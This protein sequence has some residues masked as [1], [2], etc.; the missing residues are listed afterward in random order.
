M[1][2]SKRLVDINVS[3]YL[4]ILYIYAPINIKRIQIII[5]IKA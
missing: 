4:S 1:T 5:I 2:F 3:Y